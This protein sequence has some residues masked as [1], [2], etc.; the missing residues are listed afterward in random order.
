MQTL[1]RSTIQPTDRLLKRLFWPTIRSRRDAELV[2][3]QGFWICCFVA[4]VWTIGSFFTAHVY[5]GLLIGGTYY[6]AATGI[7]MHSLTAAVFA[8]LCLFLDRVASLE[9]LLMEVPG[10]GNPMVGTLA[11][12]LLFFNIRATFL[13]RSWI[14]EE[15]SAQANVMRPQL[16]GL[17]IDRLLN[18]MPV[19]MW[20]HVRYL[21]Y[22]LAVLIMLSSIAAF[23]SL[24]EMRRALASHHAKDI[25]TL[26]KTTLPGR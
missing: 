12:L 21:Y 17:S 25:P 6:L 20:P 5:L 22:P 16:V 9:A 23:F 15:R 8:F 14:R 4:T 2:G 13:A 1:D 24:P 19:V 26:V 10:G 3:Q 18:R 7:R 11:L